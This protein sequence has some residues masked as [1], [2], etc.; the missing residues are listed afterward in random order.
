MPKCKTVASLEQE[1]TDLELELSNR[2]GEIY[3]L[4]KEL[5]EA[6]QL[7]KS[8]VK[9]KDFATDELSN[10]ERQLINALNKLNNCYETELRSLKLTLAA[11]FVA[12]GPGS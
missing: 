1:I 6:K 10:K 11:Q 5:T 9:A 2:R 4:N 8:A 7:L 12:S 3:D